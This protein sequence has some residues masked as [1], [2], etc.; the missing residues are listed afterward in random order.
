MRG[1]SGWAKVDASSETRS[2]HGRHTPQHTSLTAT[3]LLGLATPKRVL[4]N[5]DDIRVD[6]SYYLYYRQFRRAS[7][8]LAF[9][10][11]CK[12]CVVVSTV[13]SRPPS[14]HVYRHSRHGVGQRPVPLEIGADNGSF[15]VRKRVA[16]LAQVVLTHVVVAVVVLIT[17]VSTGQGRRRIGRR[18][19]GT[20]PVKAAAAGAATTTPTSQ[21]WA[22]L[23]VKAGA[24]WYVGDRTGHV[25]ARPRR[26]TVQDGGG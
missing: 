14:H 1:R 11:Q 16:H 10:P 13:P 15:R 19:P 9:R 23:S 26:R 12:P 7:R 24:C 17:T 6:K 4:H 5:T 25:K 2:Y 21:V 8:C 18:R 3:R 22:C 20:G